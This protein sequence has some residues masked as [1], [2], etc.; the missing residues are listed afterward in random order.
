MAGTALSADA[1]SQ[2]VLNTSWKLSESGGSLF[3]MEG[4]SLV[5]RD[6]DYVR[7]PQELTKVAADMMKNERRAAVV[8][9]AGSR[10][11]RVA[12]ARI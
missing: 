2:N 3:Q 4:C 9:G 11:G 7:R 6:T 1:G 5:E 12:A 10:G 8:R